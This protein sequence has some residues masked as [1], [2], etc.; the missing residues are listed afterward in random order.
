MSSSSITAALVGLAFVGLAMATK[1][2]GATIGAISPQPAQRDR[3]A[4]LVVFLDATSAQN[5]TWNNAQ[6]SGLQSI[7]SLVNPVN[8]K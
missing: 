4:G 1:R 6:A 2:S 8:S 5:A 3:D 7:D